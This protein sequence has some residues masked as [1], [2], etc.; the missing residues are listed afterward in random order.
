[1]STLKRSVY[2]R[3]KERIISSIS[4]SEVKHV[5]LIKPVFKHSSEGVTRHC[6]PCH[7]LNLLSG[8]IYCGP[9]YHLHNIIYFTGVQI[10]T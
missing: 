8:R 10:G 4:H 1:M 5:T 6:L 3:K 7:T 2:E 9:S